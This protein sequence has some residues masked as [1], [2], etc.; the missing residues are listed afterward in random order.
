MESHVEKFSRLSSRSMSFS[1]REETRGE[2][3]FYTKF[4]TFEDISMDE[5]LKTDI[6]LETLKLDIRNCDEMLKNLKIELENLYSSNDYL[7]A[8]FKM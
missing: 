2:E 6:T 3:E 1:V 7:L 5:Q 4:P 8:K